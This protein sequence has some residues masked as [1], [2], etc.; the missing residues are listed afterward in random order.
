MKFKKNTLALYEL[1]TTA[2]SKLKQE[3]EELKNLLE[4]VGEGRIIGNNSISG[5]LGLAEQVQEKIS[6]MKG[7]ESG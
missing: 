1:V 7:I 5:L 2:E 4:E 3:K 6:Q